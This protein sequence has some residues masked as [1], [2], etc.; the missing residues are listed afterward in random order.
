MLKNIK[1]VHK[2]VGSGGSGGG[3]GHGVVVG[4][5]RK[6]GA[7][8]KLGW[9]TLLRGMDQNNKIFPSLAK[10][11]LHPKMTA[12]AKLAEQYP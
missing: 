12:A 4:C 6:G 11:Q 1:D 9:I 3:G 2:R 8:N 7:G 5:G 10:P